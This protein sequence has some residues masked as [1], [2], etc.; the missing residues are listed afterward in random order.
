MLP[1]GVL[2]AWIQDAAPSLIFFGGGQSLQ[3]A[4]G[5]TLIGG[6]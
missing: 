5:Y 4:N 3:G 2:E 1:R 6:E